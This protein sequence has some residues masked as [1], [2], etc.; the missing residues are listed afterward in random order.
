MERAFGDQDELFSL[1]ILIPAHSPCLYDSA[2]SARFSSHTLEE[3]IRVMYVLFNPEQASMRWFNLL[4]LYWH[5]LLLL[6]LGFWLSMFTVINQYPKDQQT[7]QRL[8][9]IERMLRHLPR[10]CTQQLGFQWQSV[11]S[12][13]HSFIAHIQETGREQE[14]KH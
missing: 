2:I 8:R 14:C 4:S 7:L 1:M 13:T 10:H 12:F 6:L 9:Q 3:E 11:A 5:L